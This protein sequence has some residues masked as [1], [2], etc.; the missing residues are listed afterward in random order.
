M[1]SAEGKAM[2][3]D[4]IVAATLAPPG[5]TASGAIPRRLVPMLTEDLAMFVPPCGEDVILVDVGWY[6]NLDPAGSFIL[7]VVEGG[8]WED[9]TAEFKTRDPV[10]LLAKLREVLAGIVEELAW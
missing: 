5:W 4:W 1:I 10:E 9:P 2:P 7:Y 3:D 8:D 6:P